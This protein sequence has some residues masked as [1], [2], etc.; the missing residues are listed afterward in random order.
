MKNSSRKDKNEGAG[1]IGF[2][3]AYKNMKYPK[4][5]YV[6]RDP[7]AKPDEESIL[8]WERVENTEDGNVA[9]YRLERIVRKITEVLIK[10]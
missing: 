9:V 1:A 3:P 8:A 10:P 2:G 7:N 4:T 6:Q 5:I